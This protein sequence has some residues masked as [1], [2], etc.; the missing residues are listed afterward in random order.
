MIDLIRKSFAF[1]EVCQHGGKFREAAKKTGKEPLDFSANINPLGSPPLE[2][3]IV[4]ELKRIGYYPDNDYLEFRQ[5]AARFVGVNPEN[6]VP[7]NGSSELIRLF[8]ETVLGDG[9]LALIPSPTFGEYENQ[10]RLAGAE[11]RHTELKEGLPDVSDADLGRAKALFFC[12]PNNPTGALFS[13][14]EVAELAKRCE[15]SRTF[16]LVDEAFIELSD[17]EQSI[18]DLAPA[19][20]FLF[21]MRSLTKSFGIPGLRLGFGVTN[22]RLAN[23]MNRARIPWSISSLAAAAATY[24]LGQDEFLKRSRE[25]IR[26]ELAFL[27]SSL[28][29]LGLLPLPS[30]VNFILV[31]I[32]ES[33]LSS[34]RLCENMG[35]QG[36]L[37]RDCQSFGLG[38]RYI[39]IAVRNREENL[40]LLE[41]LE[42]A[43]G[44]RG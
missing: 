21:V 30:R 19:R 6:V 36:V 17:P 13:R 5:S 3:V 2:E 32:S 22:E 43:I 25:V 4:H 8:S 31:D 14:E 29:G 37:I 16:L 11:I 44:C 42:L 35:A 27:D 9:G 28:R 1:A 41:A 38:K 15:K 12:N 33:G 24:L 34:D 26:E 39:R 20:E 23:I 10:S 40:R 7:G 18:A